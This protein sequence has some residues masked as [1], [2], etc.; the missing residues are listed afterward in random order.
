VTNHNRGEAK[1]RTPRLLV[2]VL[3]VLL[4]AVGASSASGVIV[5]LKN[6]ATLSYQPAPGASSNGSPAG[7]RVFD[8]VFTNLDYSGGPVMPANTNYTIYWDPKKIG[9]PEG[10]KTGVNTYFKDLEHDSAGHENVESVATQYNDAAGQFAQYQ[11]KFGGELVDEHGYPASG[12]KRATI[13]L[14][15]AQLR[16]ELGK[17]VLEHK[18]PTDL[19]Y[20]YFLLTPAGVESCFEA[21]GLVCSAN[22]TEHQLYCA[23]HGAFEIET[24]VLVYSNDPFVN[25][26]NCDEPTH[27]INGPSDSALF[28]GLSHEH[29]ES[30][31]DPEPNNAW[32][33]WSFHE[34]GEDGDKC[35]T[36]NPATE[37][38]TPLGETEGV[39]K[40]LMKY[41]QEI[42]GHKYWYQQEWSN[43]G[44]ACLQR[45]TFEAAEA[46]AAT[47][48]S[49]KVS[50]NEVK[51]DATGSATGANV[52]YVWQFNDFAGHS[53]NK[54]FETEAL[55][56]THLFPGS[57]TYTVALT[58]MLTTGA[59]KGT[60][61][62]VLVKKSQAV[63]FKSSAPGSATVGGAMY[64]VEAS[65][66]SGLAVA[67]TIDAA[68]SSV[69]SIAG[70]TV[71]FI[72]AGTCTIDANQSGNAEYNA[73]HQVQQSFAVKKAQSVEFKSTAP[74]SA[75]VGGAM[76]SV[77]ASATSGI[78]V[79][80]TIDAAS[81]SVCS[82]AGSTVSFIGAGTC[83][84][85]A[86]QSGNAEYKAAPQVQQAFAVIKGSQTIMFTSIAPSSA[87]IGGPSYGA[88]AAASSGLTVELTIDPA[89]SS[90]CSR[91]GPTVSFIGAGTCTID[92]NQVGDSNYNA[93]T[94]V[95]QS[96]AVRKSQSITFTSS[97]PGSAT[98]GGATYAVTATASSGLPVA[99]TI[100]AAS[101]SVCSISGSSVSFTAA[102]TCTI[103]ANQTGNGTY[104]PA[105]Q[106]QQSLA[107][108]AG[109]HLGPG[110]EEM[111]PTPNSNFTPGA[112]AFNAKTGVLTVS[113]QVN[114]A[115][116]LSWLL[117]FQNGKFGVFVSRT[118]KCKAGFVRLNGRCRRSKVV[119]AEGSMA[120][121][122]AGSVQITIK[123][124]SSGLK[125]LRNALKRK[126]GLAVSMTVTF[127][128]TLGGSPVSHSQSLTLK[129]KK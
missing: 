97:A 123:P 40:V 27:H 90:V 43:K 115:G 109:S 120:V 82:I 51:F 108:A 125:A 8:E 32:T 128:S 29:N 56:T 11:S 44:H 36:F 70:S 54:T 31:T 60:A 83:T 102:G 87:S 98:A 66:T 13:C 61:K 23:Y 77:E 45:L 113:E 24:G 101:S 17:F 26:K 95:Q 79:A 94:Q 127:Q 118:A 7:A 41:N 121:A 85:D 15:D 63:E 39:G 52:R 91:A 49:A 116:T 35:R 59:S 33:D 1:V 67:L 34:S 92:A 93:A 106:V 37:F 89:S 119:F 74:G 78:A 100:D 112:V 21:A 122:G 48:T 18:L 38:G 22:A 75:T 50:G 30:I 14:T 4:F 104:N 65:A 96:F 105:A 88:A 42:N 86:N 124:S 46:P 10:F 55:T 81:S 3:V 76:Y 80:L 84:I 117:T 2:P 107:V 72:G 6:G 114:N 73:A 19:E 16:T 129:L 5:H 28:G 110:M 57:G 53:Q 64:S 69:C 20:E 9:Y 25:G 62:Q 126:K 68:S 12:C 47:F 58:V 71:S 99:L 103:D 111:L